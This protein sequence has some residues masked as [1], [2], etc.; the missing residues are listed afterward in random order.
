MFVM[1]SLVAQKD[2][3]K[4]NLPISAGSCVTFSFW[5]QD[6]DVVA[7]FVALLPTQPSQEIDSNLIRA[8]LSIWR[9]N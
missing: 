3:Q 7:H 1:Y 6:R 2:E 5:D 8:R 9:T 4:R